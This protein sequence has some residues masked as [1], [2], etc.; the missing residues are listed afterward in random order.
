[1]GEDLTR[2]Q[3]IRFEFY[4]TLPENYKRYEL[5]FKSILRYS[6]TNVAPIY[7]GPDVKTCCKVRA[8]LTDID[9]KKLIRKTGVD[10]KKYYEVHYCLVLS[11]ATANMKFSLE[12][13]G[14]EM[15]SVEA[16]YT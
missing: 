13:D 3:T 5:I 8:D 1:M 15:G 14:K 2:D 7:P 4:R 11:T 12:F 6:E 10:G 9:R 16:T